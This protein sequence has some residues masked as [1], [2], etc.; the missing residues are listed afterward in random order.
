[1][2]VKQLSEKLAKKV[3]VI[4][5][6]LKYEIPSPFH[7]AAHPYLDLPSGS[8]EK[9]VVLCVYDILSGK[10]SEDT[11]HLISPTEAAPVGTALEHGSMAA[12]FSYDTSPYASGG[13]C[14]DKKNYGM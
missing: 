10:K 8:Q 12:P 11:D 6:S 7:P 3:Q 9:P 13:A 5:S 14:T 2:C 4:V 1:M